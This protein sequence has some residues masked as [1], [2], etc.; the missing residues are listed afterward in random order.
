[1]VFKSFKFSRKLKN[2]AKGIKHFAKDIRVE[3]DPE[4]LQEHLVNLQ[5]E[6]EKQMRDKSMS[7]ERKKRL[8][9]EVESF[10]TKIKKKQIELNRLRKA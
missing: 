6:Y 2:Y 3:V 8:R 7:E 1:M 9:I 4:K 5:K 10:K